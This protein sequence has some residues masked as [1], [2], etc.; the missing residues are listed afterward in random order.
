MK[1]NSLKLKLKKKRM[2]NVVKGAAL[3]ALG[4]PLTKGVLGGVTTSVAFRSATG[5]R[6]TF[7]LGCVFVAGANIAMR[8][9]GSESEVSSRDSGSD[10]QA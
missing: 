4:H 1:R 6:D 5:V 3:D 8:G 9:M 10:S 7:V 2:L